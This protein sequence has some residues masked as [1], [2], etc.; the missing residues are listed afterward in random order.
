MRVTAS[1]WL[2][3][4]TRIQAFDWLTISVTSDLSMRLVSTILATL[5][6]LFIRTLR[7][8]VSR[9]HERILGNSCGEVCYVEVCYRVK[10]L[11]TLKV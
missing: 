10:E 1:D 8:V 6:K 11:G 7:E 5:S 4:L 2:S 3:E 9:Q